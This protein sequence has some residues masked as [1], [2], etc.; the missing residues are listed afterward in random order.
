MID[1]PL[2]LINCNIPEHQIRESFPELYEYLQK[3]QKDVAGRYLCKSKRYWYQQEQREPAPILCTYMGRETT[4]GASPFRFILNHSNAIVTNSYL[5]LYPKALYRETSSYASI[6]ESIWCELSQLPSSAITSEGR[7]Y[8]GGL[9][10]I[11]PKELGEV[12]C[13]SSFAPSQLQ[14]FQIT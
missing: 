14:A 7:V 12:I 5:M 2:F 6:I 9:R 8:G 10:K 1:N 13:K 3:G 11:E 4:E